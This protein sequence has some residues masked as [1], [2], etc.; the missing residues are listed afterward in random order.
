M[1]PNLERQPAMAMSA[2]NQTKVSQAAFLERHSFQ[3][4]MPVTSRMESPARAAATLPMPMEPPKT[5]RPTVRRR[6]PAMSFS[7]PLMGPSFW[8]SR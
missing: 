8:S 6:V 4:T 3:E 1:K 5:H 2:A 7:S